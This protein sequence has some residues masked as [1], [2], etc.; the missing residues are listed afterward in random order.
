[1]IGRHAASRSLALG[2]GA[3]L[4]AGAIGV[5]PVAAQD[6]VQTD[7]WDSLGPVTISIQG[8]NASKATLEALTAQFTQ[9]YPNVTFDL[10]FKSFDDFMSTVLQVADSSDAPAIIFCNPGYTVDGP[11]V[12]AGL[13]VPLDAYYE[14][15]GWNDWYPEGTRAQFQFTEDGQTFGQG[16]IWGV[17]E[18]ADFVGVFYN[19]DKLAALGLEPPTT[20]AELEAAFAAAKAAGELPIKLGNLEGW[21]AT[22]ALGIAQGADVPAADIRAWVFGQDGADFASAA[23]LQAATTFKG[24]VDQGYIDG[25]AANGLAYEQAWQDFA[26][27]DGVFLLGGHWLAANLRDAMG[28]DKVGFIAPPPGD[29]G[30][31]AAVAALSLPFHISS[32][33]QHQDL[34]AGVI[35]F[36]MNPDKG[37]TYLDNGRIPAALG[38]VGEPS[39]A[40][41]AQ[42]KTAWER[43]ATDDGLM[44]YQDWATDTMFD[45]LTGSLQE[46]VGNRITPEDFVSTVQDDW[47]KFTS[48]R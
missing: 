43:I 25:A 42:L 44:Y 11:L 15:Y 18:S 22:H 8:E 41:T 7:G 28:A 30:K 6:A 4:M 33:S 12:E 31:V 9:Q 36:V 37:Q 10:Q 47:T 24:W 26:K 14:A 45:T 32:K 1:M 13:I 29:S 5:V 23:N 2:A 40:V 34:A 27:G 48:S 20:F 3:L 38:S 19:V 21:P 17:A 46:L 16:P 35:N 39:D